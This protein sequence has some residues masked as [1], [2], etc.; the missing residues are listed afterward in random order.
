ME[1]IAG[2]RN[3]T[4]LAKLQQLLQPTIVLPVDVQA[5]QTARQLM[6]SFFLSHGLA[7]ADSL[8]AATA[9]TQGLPLY[10]RNVR[11]FQMIPMLTVVC[12]Y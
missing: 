6:E 7:I 12:P 5:S 9:L 8:I 2:C 4:E 10:T 3:A 1:L 11:H